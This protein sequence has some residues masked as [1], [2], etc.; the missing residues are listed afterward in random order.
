MA[1]LLGLAV[2]DDREKRGGEGRSVIRHRKTCGRVSLT[3][4]WWGHRLS[5]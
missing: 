4:Y 3:L 2:E 5:S 1:E